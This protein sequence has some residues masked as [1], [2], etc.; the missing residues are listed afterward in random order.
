M[1]K[2][3]NFLRDVAIPDLP[4]DVRTDYM[5][6]AATQVQ[7]QA[8]WLFVALLMTTPLAVLITP[9]DAGWFV[10]F[11][12]PAA[13]ALYCLS[14]LFSLFKDNQF[15]TKPWR[16]E[17]FIVESWVSS[18]I[19]A[20]ICTTWAIASWL[21]A[22]GA[23]RLH[24]PVILV[25]GALATAYCV[26]SIRAAAAMHLLIDIVPIAM[27]LFFT[28]SML[29]MAAAVS[30]ALAGVFQ[31][32]MINVHHQQVVELLLLKRKSQTLAL[33][34]PLTGLLNRRALLDFAEALGSDGGQSR[35]LLIDID[36]FKSVNDSHGHDVGDGVLQ[37]VARL[38]D[39]H[40]G[41]NVSS[42]RLGGE[43][44][45]LLGTPEALPADKAARLL[46]E[47]RNAPMPHGGQITVS[48]GI[49]EGTLEDDRAWRTLY[50]LAD[51]ALYEAKRQGRDRHFHA[52]D[53]E[54]ARPPMRRAEDQAPA[55]S[56]RRNVA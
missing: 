6:A 46:D 21:G 37:E 44:F 53:L 34:D 16:A 1:T 40:G 28:G 55:P 12:L 5:V 9:E 51:D 31:W 42:A 41:N 18:L 50:K 11:A 8:R 45:A 38:I 32:R 27:L 47:I 54:T 30:L 10:R 7:K 15:E 43:E 36:R 56:P 20:L 3:S 19:G 17:R 49:A 35:L 24:F 13:M 23:E 4:Q 52:A 29:D 26:A 48:I 2:V 14:G 22:E 33:T 25:M 39:A